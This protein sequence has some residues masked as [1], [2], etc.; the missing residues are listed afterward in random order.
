MQSLLLA[1]EIP[2][3]I[4]KNILLVPGSSLDLVMYEPRYVEMVLT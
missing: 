4:A 2:V 1:A 3:F